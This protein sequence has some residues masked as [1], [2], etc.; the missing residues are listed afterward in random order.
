MKTKILTAICLLSCVLTFTACDWGG[1]VKVSSTGAPYEICIIASENLW[2]TTAGDT[3]KNI[4]SKD[5]EMINQS[6]PIFDVYDMLD[7]SYTAA[8]RRSRNILVLKTGTEYEKSD[9][10]ADYNKYSAP[11]LIVTVTA[12]TADS[13]TAFLGRYQNELVKLYEIEERDR[14]AEKAKTNKD[15]NI[16]LV[17]KQKFGFEMSIPKGYTLR[18]DTTDFMWISFELPLASVGF[19]VYTYP[20]DSVAAKNET[21]GNIIAARNISI[22]QVP[23]PKEG[24]YMATSEMVMPDQKLLTVHGRKWNQVR[25]FWDVKGDFMGG[26]FINY[27]TY[28]KANKRM[29]AIDGY[30]YS[31]S[32]NNN[33]PMRNYIRQVEAIFMTVQIPE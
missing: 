23:G 17:I 3:V 15:K 19:V 22:M 28:D 6:E 27:T 5:V 14:F 31:P 4:F 29:I 13:M 30:V 12:P 8:L 2:A 25:G 1:A 10:T 24:S 11:Q 32:P 26:P 16:A 33:V 20:A 21:A 18:N 7:G 9:M